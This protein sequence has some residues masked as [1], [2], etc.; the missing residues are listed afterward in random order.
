[1]LLLHGT[2]GPL[3]YA[4][5]LADRPR[6]L[7]VGHHEA[8]PEAPAAPAEAPSIVLILGES[9]CR[10]AVC[11]DRVP[12]CPHSPAVDTAAPLR[13]GYARSFAVASCT[14]IVSTALWTG[15][16]MTA[17]PSAVAGAPLVWDWARAR[18]YRTAYFTSQNLLF[19]QMDLFLRGV[20][21][22]RIREARH[23]DITVRID[24]GSPDEDTTG[25]ALAFLEEAPARRSWSS[26]TPT[27]TRRTGRRPAS[28]RTPA[29]MRGRDT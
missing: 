14:D 20:G 24:D 4:F 8:L 1:M 2:G 10:D 21:F 12:G 11:A 23:R 22:H 16:P 18:G 28:R 29:T 3:L 17:S 13:V 19:Q 25:E 26:I 27:P 6:V 5:G 15:L 7:P 9:V